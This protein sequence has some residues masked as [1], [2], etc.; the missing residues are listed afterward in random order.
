MQRE[1][2]HIDKR[3]HGRADRAD[4]VPEKWPPDNQQLT[5]RFLADTGSP[6]RRRAPV[7][8]RISSVTTARRSKL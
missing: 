2:K 7:D 6:L 1:S 4:D 3:D 8:R 5:A